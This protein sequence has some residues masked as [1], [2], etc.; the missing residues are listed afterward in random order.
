MVMKR[1]DRLPPEDR[2]QPVQPASSEP[3]Q[4]AGQPPT[5]VLATATVTSEKALLR[6]IKTHNKAGRPVMHIH[7]PRLRFE[8]GE[9]LQVY[10]EEVLTDGGVI[11][12]KYADHP[13]LYVR[14]EYVSIAGM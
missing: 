13:D 5:E 7:E 10:P 14:M 11:Y 12:L 4:D 9:T 6:E 8:T 2:P 3:E 1:D